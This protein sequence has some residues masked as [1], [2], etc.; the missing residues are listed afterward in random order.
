M[1]WRL[2]RAIQPQDRGR[3]RALREIR[4]KMTSKAAMTSASL[5]IKQASFNA[6]LPPNGSLHQ[7]QRSD[8]K[9]KWSLGEV[10]K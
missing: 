8:F 5:M 7:P 10:Y 9:L 4:D 1:C 3:C 6:Y 2:S